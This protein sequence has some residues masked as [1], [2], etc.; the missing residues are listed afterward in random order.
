MQF[1]DQLGG[2]DQSGF[3]SGVA[4]QPV[5]AAWLPLRVGG[6][7]PVQIRQDLASVLDTQ[8]PGCT[9]ETGGREVVQVLV[10]R[11]GPRPRR[12]EQPVTSPHQTLSHPAPGQQDLICTGRL[13][14]LGHRTSI[15]GGTAAAEA[16][17]GRRP[18]PGRH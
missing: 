5:P 1:P 8:E 13:L 18:Q 6:D 7:V 3:G 2:P 12:P 4:W 15:Q 16:A 10:H 14:L 17:G 9:R 11:S